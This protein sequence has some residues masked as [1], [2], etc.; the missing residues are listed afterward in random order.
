M[1]DLEAPGAILLVH[2]GELADV[3]Q[4]LDALELGFVESTPAATS[5]DAYGTAAIV[6]SGPQYLLDRLE[7]G[8]GDG[9]IRVAILEGEARTLRSMLSRGGIEWMV[10]RPFHPAALRLLL[11]HCIYRGPEK[12]STRRV[13]VGAAIHFQ[14]G[15]RKRGALLAEISERDCRFLSDRP[16]SVGKR[17]KLRLP[18]E[19]MQERALTLAGRVVRTARAQEDDGAH[20]V[21]VVFDP[22]GAVETLRLKDLM[23]RHERGPAVL[24]GATAR[25]AERSR[26][27]DPSEGQRVARSVIRLGGGTDAESPDASEGGCRPGSPDGEERRRDAR[28]E[29]RRRVIALGEEATRVLVGRDISTAGMRVDPT[30]TLSL[31]QTLQ[32]AIHVPGHETPLVVEVRVDRDDGP[33][34]LLMTFQELSPTARRYLDEMLGGLAGVSTASDGATVVSEIVDA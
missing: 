32:I 7:A 2:A 15:W 31:G 9:P 13:G 3:R 19:L 33:R 12:R 8:E 22:P 14:T 24:A 20:E 26:P 21:C 11:L 18:G 17:L 10:R 6:V 4:L 34:G 25:H 16:V 28:H 1:V 29:F 27:S 5:V 23:K 30:S